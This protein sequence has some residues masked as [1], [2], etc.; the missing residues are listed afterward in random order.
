MDSKDYYKEVIREYLDQNH[1]LLLMELENSNELVEVLENRAAR[2]LEQMH[3]SNNPQDEKEIYYQE[4][5]TF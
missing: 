1:P 2:Y 4:M 3:R 5:L